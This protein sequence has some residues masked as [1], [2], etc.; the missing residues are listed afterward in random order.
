[1]QIY[2][3]YSNKSRYKRSSNRYC[4]QLS[5]IGILQMAIAAKQYKI[6]YVGNHLDAVDSYTTNDHS[7][8][9]EYIT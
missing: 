5:P 7:N 3:L 2:H 9:M 4:G 1:M 8:G 6:T